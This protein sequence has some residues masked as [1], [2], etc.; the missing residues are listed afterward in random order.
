MSRGAADTRRRAWRGRARASL[1][2]RRGLAGCPG[3]AV[4]VR[5]GPSDAL[6]PLPELTLRAP[7]GCHAAGPRS[8]SKKAKQALAEAGFGGKMRVVELDETP[9][10]EALQEQLAALSGR[11]TVPQVF[12]E[13]QFFGG[14]EDVV[15]AVREGK[16]AP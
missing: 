14:S 16:L 13:G 12:L 1:A 11:D 15:K 9:D 5:A 6:A 2:F 4:A 7:R 8:Y 3:R 10:G